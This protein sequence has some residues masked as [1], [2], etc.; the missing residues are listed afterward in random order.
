MTEIPEH[1]LKRSKSAKGQKTGD[2][3]ASTA[4]SSSSAVTPAASETPAPSGPPAIAAAAA[5]I[6]KDVEPAPAAPEPH[7]VAASRA[8]NRIPMWALPL[9]F[10]L[11][12]WALSYAG[13]M[14]LPPTEDLLF[15]DAAQAYS[16]CASCHG[17]TGG[18]GVGYALSGG[19]VLQ[20]FPEPVDQMAYVAR[21]SAAIA[22]ETYGANGRRVAGELGVMPAHKDTYTLLELELVVFYER[23][24]LSEEDTTDASYLEWMD[25]LRERIEANEQDPI[26]LDQ[27]LGCA[28]PAITPGGGGGGG[29]PECPGPASA[30]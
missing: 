24:I 2:G 26:D 13:T 4:E 29:G 18:G 5:A 21:G 19:E 14:Q 22:G 20:T 17:A 25:N 28:D 16:S 6:P 3:P 10:A 11:P 8:R 30:G 12:I 9:V 1:L 15:V 7:Y 27:L 23:A